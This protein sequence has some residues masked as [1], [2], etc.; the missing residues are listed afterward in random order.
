MLAGVASRIRE[1]RPRDRRDRISR[2]PTHQ[3]RVARKVDGMLP[4]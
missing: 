3:V 1:H 4:S 2:P